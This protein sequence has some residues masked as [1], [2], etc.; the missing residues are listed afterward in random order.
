MYVKDFY[1]FPYKKD[2]LNIL[3]EYIVRLICSIDKDFIIKNLIVSK[4]CRE[5]PLSRQSP[6]S[7]R[8]MVSRSN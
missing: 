3:Q 5:N 7:L 4:I 2:F 1:L 8:I 6:F